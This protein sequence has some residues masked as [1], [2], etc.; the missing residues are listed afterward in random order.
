M[1]R[2]CWT[3]GNFRMAGYILAS[4]YY[5]TSD[6]SKCS[7]KKLKDHTESPFHFAELSCKLC[8]RCALFTLVHAQ[9]YL[10]YCFA[11]SNPSK[12]TFLCPWKTY[13]TWKCNHWG[14]T[15]RIHAPYLQNQVCTRYCLQHWHTTKILS[16]DPYQS[17]APEKIKEFDIGH[18][19]A[20]KQQT[21]ETADLIVFAKCG[22]NFS[23]HI[24]KAIW[25]SVLHCVGC[26]KVESKFVGPRKRLEL[27]RLVVVALEINV[28]HHPSVNY[29]NTTALL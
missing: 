8:S 26:P 4:Y 17:R 1:W 29:G 10:D 24:G 20:L 23:S 9:C 7:L 11:N 21:N 12:R 15:G 14:D 18:D 6:S 13:K 3:N 25:I 19:L 28:V 5:Y 22:S 2:C 27:W 16:N